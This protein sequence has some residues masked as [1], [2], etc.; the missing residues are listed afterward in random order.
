MTFLILKGSD[1]KK[2]ERKNN[3]FPNSRDAVATIKKKKK[4]GKWY[5]LLIG[6]WLIILKFEKATWACGDST[7]EVW[8]SGDAHEL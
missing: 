5:F 7:Y 3:S 4:I 1:G 6:Q 8:N 2:K